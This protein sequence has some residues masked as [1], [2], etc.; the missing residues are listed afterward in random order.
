MAANEWRQAEV[1]SQ[2]EP[3]MPGHKAFIRITSQRDRAT[4][5]TRL[6]MASTLL[7]PQQALD[8]KGAHWQIENGLHWMLDVHLGRGP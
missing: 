5:L 4:P 6:F 2:T 1:V 8:V 3:L 7:L